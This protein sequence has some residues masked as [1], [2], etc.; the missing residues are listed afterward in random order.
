LLDFDKKLANFILKISFLYNNFFNFL[1]I[2]YLMLLNERIANIFPTESQIPAEFNLT[3][4]IH[5]REYLVNGEMRIWN[6]DTH[7][8]L[9]PVYIK[10]ANG[11]EQ[12]VVGSYPLATEVE[13]LEALDAA[14][15]AYNH[16]RGEW[17]TMTIPERIACLEKFTNMMTEKKN[18]IVNL[19][20]W[21]IGKSY[22]DSVKEFDRTVQYNYD[23]IDAL[24]DLDRN[25]SRFVI[26]QGIIGQIRR[27]PLGI[28]LCMGP[29][30]YPLNETFATLI[31]A[32]IMGNTVLFK[33]PKHGTL[34]HYPLL[35]AFRQC[36]PKGVV[37]T[38]YGR[39]NTIVGPMI[40]TGNINVL[41]LIGSSK[42][43]DKLKKS[44]PKSNRLKA[45]LGLDAKNL[46]IIL[47]SADI[48]ATVKECI[49]GTL[50]F[51]G[52]RCTALKMIFVHNKVKDLFI[53]RFS[54]EVSKLK[55]GMPWEKGVQITP[56]P[57]PQ[58]PDYLKECIEDAVKQGA[59]IM[60]EGGGL[61]NKS[62]VFPAVLY[63]IKKGMK[64]YT[65]EQ[66]GPVIPI[67]SFEDIEEPIQYMIESEHGQQL[68]I[69][70]TNPTQ[71]AK[72][73]DPL[74][75][76]VCRVNIN[77]QCQRGPDT[78]PF[79]GRKDSGENTLSVTDALR[80]F[81]IRTMVATKQTEE[82]KAILN[83]IVEH[84]ESKFLSTRFIF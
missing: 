66:F 71:I 61:T 29:F 59:E 22:T 46:A 39:G 64:L 3:E 67:A 8:V 72:L 35:E 37:N 21:E 20:M 49:L 18:E 56:L 63:P 77:A 53:K 19:L 80:A 4:P 57:E 31:P 7:T 40:A 62:F 38:V 75:N 41:T 76:Q 60:N 82:N 78:F 11:L 6:G 48:E 73:I 70:G 33:P 25:H 9:S 12:K 55:I 79:A 81:S 15:K 65:E 34:L 14:V 26:E 17:P 1:K 5:Q 69:F 43:A 13:A 36:F 52:Q 50:S 45:V 84:H 10:T 47:D 44:H 54:E 30:N 58:K 16:G 42:V 32:L 24:K 23:T 28:V 74:V 68:S 2:T 83:Y 27:A 51:N